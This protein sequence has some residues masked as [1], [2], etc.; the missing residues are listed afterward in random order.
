VPLL[1][2]QGEMM[3]GR[4]WLF[5]A[6]LLNI[7]LSAG[8]CAQVPGQPAQTASAPA[9]AGPVEHPIQISSIGEVPSTYKPA[10]TA[11]YDS[12]RKSKMVWKISIA[13]ML[14]ASAFDA[15]TSVG[16]HESN[17]LLRSSD[18]NFGGKGAAIKAGLAGISIAP[19][20]FLRDRHDLR[21]IFT[22]VNFA[23][24]GLFTGVAIH[25]TTIK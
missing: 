21:K 24:A 13:T 3:N 7:F 16:K 11:Y 10:Q 5:A 23:S 17:P 2:E 18:G 19:Q 6:L 1:A 12:E 4:S 9:S 14:A 22:V 8:I 25:N 15:Y 20:I